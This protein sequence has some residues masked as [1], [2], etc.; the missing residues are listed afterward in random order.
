MAISA[1]RKFATRSKVARQSAMALKLSMNQRS[2]DC[3]W[4]KAPA[5]IISP[6]NDTLPLKY[7]GAATRMGATMVTQPKPAVTQVRLAWPMTMRRVAASTLP[8][9]SSMRRFSSASPSASEMSSTC[10]L[11]RTRENRRS[12]SRA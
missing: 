6:P 12:A 8:R 5:A 4:L 7:S 3:A 2:E 10:S 9:C 1:W 11:M